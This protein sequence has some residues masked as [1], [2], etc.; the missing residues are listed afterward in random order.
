MLLP[1]YIVAMCRDD[2]ES[3]QSG[4]LDSLGG[5]GFDQA[6]TSSKAYSRFTDL[7]SESG[8]TLRPIDHMV[9]ISLADGTHHLSH[10]PVQPKVYAFNEDALSKPPHWPQI[11]LQTFNP[12]SHFFCT[13][14]ERARFSDLLLGCW[15]VG[16]E[17]L[18]FS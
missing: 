3:A 6:S 17:C 16:L 15:D 10:C 9:S 7:P 14:C 13:P 8:A 2:R 11:P 5:F 12:A 18:S 1:Q 4:G